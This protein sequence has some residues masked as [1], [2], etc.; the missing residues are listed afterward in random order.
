MGTVRLPGPDQEWERSSSLGKG[1]RWIGS[2]GFPRLLEHSLH[3]PM[4]GWGQVL[5]AILPC[6]FEGFSLFFLFS[7][8][9]MQCQAGAEYGTLPN[10][11]DSASHPVGE[12]S[13]KVKHSWLCLA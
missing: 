3:L 4:G 13:K 10:A 8:F 2:N 7:H 11:V 5:Q 1:R 9:T 6:V 12:A